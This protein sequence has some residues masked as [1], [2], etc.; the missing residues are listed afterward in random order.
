[1]HEI[2]YDYH[3]FTPYALETHFKN[4]AYTSW[5]IK[6]LGGSNYHFALS[7]ALRYEK[8]SESKRKLVKP[9]VNYVIKFLVRKDNKKI[10]FENGQLY[11]GL[12]GFVTK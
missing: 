9:F 2:P 8:I 6:P 11:S 5:D 10:A 12:Y 7:L 3:R 4:T 1:M